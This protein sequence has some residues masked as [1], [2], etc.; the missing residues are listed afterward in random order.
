MSFPQSRDEP[1]RPTKQLSKPE[2]K[3]EP[4][5][6]RRSWQTSPNRPNT[7]VQPLPSPSPRTQ[8]ATQPIPSRSD[9]YPLHTESEP[10]S[11]SGRGRRLQTGPARVSTYFS[12]VYSVVAD[13][14]AGYFGRGGG[15]RCDNE[16][17]GRIGVGDWFRG[18]TR[19]RHGNGNG[20]DADNGS[21]WQ[22]DPVVRDEC[23]S[24]TIRRRN[25]RDEW[26]AGT[27]H[28]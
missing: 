27:Y 3:S 23:R 1:E 11:S 28:P 4:E 10:Q 20:D 12:G 8:H 24:R 9:K 2:P 21:V 7:R 17:D 16:Y 22:D 15:S 14:P 6:E 13:L 19:R 5:P 25:R 26:D 18:G